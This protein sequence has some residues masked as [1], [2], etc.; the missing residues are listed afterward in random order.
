MKTLYDSIFES[1][2]N[3]VNN[4]ELALEEAQILN[5]LAY[6]RYATESGVK[7]KKSNP[8]KA[9]LEKL[10]EIKDAKPSEFSDD[11][12]I[13]E[14]VDKHYDEILRASKLLEEEPEKI[15]KKDIKTT[16]AVIIEFIAYFSAL[17]VSASIESLPLFVLGCIA[18]LLFICH[19]F[20]AIICTSSRASADVESVK[21]LTK[22]KTSLSKIKTDKLPESMKK[23]ISK[24]QEKID[25][26]ETAIYAKF[27]E[28]KESVELYNSLVSVL[29]EKVENGDLSVEE[30]V[31]VDMAAYEK[32]ILA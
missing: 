19:T 8:L 29:N 14:F 2:E 22:I 6:E 25:D 18:A 30:A 12:E 16:I 20:V 26:A 4:G 27:K 28:V 32:Y 3:K 7:E 13:K 17:T 9:H 24:M 11:T 31:M 21:N 1:L 15:D 10:K 23:K 5:D